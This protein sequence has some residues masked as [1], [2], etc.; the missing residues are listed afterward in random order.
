MSNSSKKYKILMVLIIIVVVC[1]L[2][3]AHFYTV[4]MRKKK[5]FSPFLNSE[6]LQNIKSAGGENEYSRNRDIFSGR[7]WY[8]F[9]DGDYIYSF[10]TMGYWEKA[11][12]GSR[13]FEGSIL[14][15]KTCENRC[16]IRLHITPSAKG[17]E[18]SLGLT[19][20]AIVDE[21][22]TVGIWGDAVDKRGKPLEASYLTKDGRQSW[23]A[24][25]EKFE[26][27]IMAMFAT[28]NEVFGEDAFR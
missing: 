5:I 25:Y 28:I 27:E 19:D 9:Y 3:G 1:G 8:T 15:I 14:I 4:E 26:V 17:W 16:R 23:L 22:D 20:F 24:L 21:Y 18:Y 11:S 2:I 12:S 6:K 13:K 7:E 10:H